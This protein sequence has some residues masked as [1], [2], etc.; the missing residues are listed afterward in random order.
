MWKENDVTFAKLDTLICKRLTLKDAANAFV[1][2]EAAA[3]FLVTWV[4]SR[5]VFLKNVHKVHD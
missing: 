4:L 2:I 1:S 5:Q 3:A